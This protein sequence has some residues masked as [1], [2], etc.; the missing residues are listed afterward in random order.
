ML[1][2]A[3]GVEDD[4]VL[5]RRGDCEYLAFSTNGSQIKD[6]V[7]PHLFLSVTRLPPLAF[8]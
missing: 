4:S 2:P 3:A 1:S 5:R 6:A 7:I 8:V